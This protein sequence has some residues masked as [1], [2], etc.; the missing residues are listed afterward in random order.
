MWVWLRAFAIFALVVATPLLIDRLLGRHPRHAGSAWFKGYS[1]DSA[2]DWVG[3]SLVVLAIAAFL[4]WITLAIIEAD[5]FS[6]YLTLA[7]R[8]MNAL[9]R[10]WGGG[11]AAD[12]RKK[13]AEERAGWLGMIPRDKADAVSDV[14]KQF[15]DLNQ[16]EL[17]GG[18]QGDFMGKAR[19]TAFLL[20]EI[21]E[22]NVKNAQLKI[23][24]EFK[25]G[26]KLPY[27]A[28]GVRQILDLDH[29]DATAGRFKRPG[30]AWSFPLWLG[31]KLYGHPRRIIMVKPDKSVVENRGVIDEL[32]RQLEP[33]P[34]K[35][36]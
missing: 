29:F 23:E 15:F 16:K 12:A 24:N 26:G 9:L 6:N 36:S 8:E 33:P 5:K 34:A 14:Y 17:A 32:N 7:E 20:R 18:A 22:G 3:Y 19:I 21:Y 11:L 31:A 25:N 2:I 13:L 4:I 30:V 28:A 35:A 27:I 1:W 10:G